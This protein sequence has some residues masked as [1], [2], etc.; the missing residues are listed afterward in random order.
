MRVPTLSILSR[1]G[2]LLL[3]GAVEDELTR[4]QQTRPSAQLP[5]LSWPAAG[6]KSGP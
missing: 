5:G 6:M 4:G 3:D 2:S 1:G